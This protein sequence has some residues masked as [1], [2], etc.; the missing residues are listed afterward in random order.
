MSRKAAT[1]TSWDATREAPP[2]SVVRE[3]SE[4]DIP[5][6]LAL[7]ASA[8]ETAGLPGCVP[9]GKGD[10]K[11]W[12]TTA[13]RRGFNFIAEEEGRLVAHLVLIRIGDA[14]KMSIFVHPD[15]RRRGIGTSLLRIAIEQ[16]KDMGVRHTW[17]ALHPEDSALQAN[18]REFGF[19]VS[20]RTEAK[21]EMVLSL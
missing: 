3:A 16:A 12:L 10:H 18:L 4:R 19:T 13:L 17:L 9:P 7:Y 11:N 8:D 2:L 15:F 14:A 21:V 5:R 1:E 20:L 6:L